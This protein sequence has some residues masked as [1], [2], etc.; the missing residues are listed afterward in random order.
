MKKILIIILM[1]L[2]LPTFSFAKTKVYKAHIGKGSI[3]YTYDWFDFLCKNEKH[4]HN[5]GAW[6]YGYVKDVEN[7]TSIY[8]PNKPKNYKVPDYLSN[9]PIVNENISLENFKG[10][11]TE[12]DAM[13]LVM[14]ISYM[15]FESGVIFGV[16]PNNDWFVVNNNGHLHNNAYGDYRH[17]K[18]MPYMDV[19]S[20]IMKTIIMHCQF[21]NR[22]PTISEKYIMLYLDTY[23]NRL[24][25][26]LD[27]EHGQ[28]Y[29]KE[30]NRIQKAEDYR[31]YIGGPIKLI[32]WC[33]LILFMFA[34]PGIVLVILKFVFPK[35]SIIYSAVCTLELLLGIF[36]VSYWYGNRR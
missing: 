27:R 36:A 11:F 5:K 30:Y 32:G 20:S 34:L 6:K 10:I 33:L 14:I 3:D 23:G 17:N 19:K 2:L 35:G 8:I 13:R 18:A 24:C 28:I 26:K 21:E 16:T 31:M 25:R 7:G 22:E 15:D 4:D 29:A 9:Y 12:K 1:L